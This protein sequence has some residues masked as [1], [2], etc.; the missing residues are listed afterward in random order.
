[1]FEGVR[2]KDTACKTIV[3]EGRPYSRRYQLLMKGVL[4]VGDTCIRYVT[5]ALYL[6]SRWHT[7]IHV[8][9]SAR[10]SVLL[11]CSRVHDVYFFL[12]LYM[13]VGTLYCLFSHK[14]GNDL[15]CGILM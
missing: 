6:L 11:G 9:P 8:N 2:L 7:Q 12:A 13:V 15:L 10:Q 4:T 5:Y 1:V 14:W 3:N